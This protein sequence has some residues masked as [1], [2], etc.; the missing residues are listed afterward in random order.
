MS[1]KSYKCENCGG[2]MEFDIKTQMLKCP[3]CETTIKIINDKDKIVE[4]TLTL[5]DRR[6]LMPEEKITQTMVCSGCGASVEM[7]SNETA[8]KC[9][10]CG[11]IL[12]RAPFLGILGV[13]SS[14]C[15]TCR[16]QLHKEKSVYG[17]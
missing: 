6:N 1:D 10:Y 13:F 3:N 11:S 9:P 17:E 8:I 12:F 2:I 4:H 7:Q 14:D 5:E 16:M 15:P